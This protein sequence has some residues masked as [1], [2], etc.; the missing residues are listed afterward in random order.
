MLRSEEL[1]QGGPGV[2]KAPTQPETMQIASLTHD[3]RGVA[4]VDGKTVFVDGALP[5]EQVVAQRLRRRRRHDEADLLEVVTAS[6]DRVAPRCAHFGVC[7][8]CALQHL[9][10]A[11]QLE[12]KQAHVAEQLAR[13][14]HVEPSRWLAPVSGPLWG[15]RRRARLGVKHVYKKGRVLVGFRERSKPYIADVRQCPVLA[16]PVGELVGALAGLVERLSIR[17]RLPQFEVAVADAATALVARV[18]DP[19]TADDLSLL[20]EFAA[21]QGVEFY[22]QPGGLDT[23]VPLDPPAT[24]LTYRLDAFDVGMTF[25]PSDFIQVNAEIN[26]RAVALAVELL[27]LEPADRVL[28]LFCGLG[29][30]TLPLARRAAQ[31]TGVEGDAGLVARAAAN[32]AANGIANATFHAADLMTD[33]AGAPWAGQPYER[34]LLDPPRAGALA[35]LELLGRIAPRRMVYVSCHPASFARDAGM[36]VNQYGFTLAAVGVMDMFPHTA[37]VETI[38]LF[39]GR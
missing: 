14:G 39:E 2:K 6:P 13:V 11:R 23:I 7:G 29:N 27:E 22:L 16:P 26:R 12:A 25:E 19:P 21:A 28:D 9:D 15:Y 35:V 34:V 36:L 1:A 3:G 10:P 4:R 31:V 5:G 24:P 38:A 20:R 30:F 8:G 32:A 17:D 33:P 18:L 37:H